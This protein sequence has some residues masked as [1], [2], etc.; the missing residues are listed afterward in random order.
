M[1]QVFSFHARPFLDVLI[2]NGVASACISIYRCTRDLRGCQPYD[3]IETLPI[4]IARASACSSRLHCFMKS[5]ND[6]FCWL[7]WVR[8]E[9]A[10]S[11][12]IVGHSCTIHIAVIS[13]LGSKCLLCWIG[14]D[15]EEWRR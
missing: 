11:A 4:W 1:I 10:L 9:I 2:W 8:E 3:W 12:Y 13:G 14:L 5:G 7:S 6:L 15:P